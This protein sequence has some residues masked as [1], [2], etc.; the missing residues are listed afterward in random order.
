MDLGT[1]A[2][3]FASVEAGSSPA[4]CVV[5]GTIGEAVSARKRRGK[6]VIT[7]CHIAYRDCNLRTQ[8]LGPG[9]RLPGVRPCG[10]L[11][12]VHERFRYKS[13]TLPRH[14][15]CTRAQQ[16]PPGSRLLQTLQLQY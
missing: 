13:G 9:C 7:G 4:L 11:A 1:E 6:G 12:P 14:E 2:P 3:E 5:S 15:Y 16:R 8:P 10:A